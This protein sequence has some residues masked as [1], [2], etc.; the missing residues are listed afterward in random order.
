MKGDAPSCGATPLRGVGPAPEGTRSG[1]WFTCPGPSGRGRKIFCVPTVLVL[2]SLAIYERPDG[3]T[4]S[5]N[6]REP[7]TAERRAP[8]AWSALNNNYL[9]INKL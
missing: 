9:I 6:Q 7:H 5:T 1:W 8:G 3:V 2:N 4:A